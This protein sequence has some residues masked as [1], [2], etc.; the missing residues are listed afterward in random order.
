MKRSRLVRILILWTLF[1]LLAAILLAVEA[2]ISIHQAEQACFF[3][4]PATPCPG[5]DDPAVTR[6]TMA[7]FALPL[8]WLIGLGVLGLGWS[9]IGRQAAGRREV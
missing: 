2:L 1:M 5:S 9:L 3:N 6:L 7:F 4:Y 8:V